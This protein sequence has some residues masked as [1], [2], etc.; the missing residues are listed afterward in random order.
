VQIIFP[1]IFYFCVK[2]LR[3]PFP[4]THMTHNSQDYTPDIYRWHC[5]TVCSWA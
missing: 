5:E 3:P 1:H 4:Y 2:K